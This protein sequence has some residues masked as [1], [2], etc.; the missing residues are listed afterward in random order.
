MKAA[1]VRAPTDSVPT[2]P[3]AGELSRLRGMLDGSVPLP[4]SAWDHVRGRQLEL[5]RDLARR[6]PIYLDSRFWFDLRRANDGLESAARSQPLLV[7]LREAVADGRAFCPISGSTFIELF[8][9]VDHQVRIRTAR[10]VQE[11]S[12]GVTLVGLEELA[13]TELEWFLVRK[14][15]L[16]VDPLVVPIWTRISYALG[17]IVPHAA[18]FSP[19]QNLALQVAAFDTLWNMPLTEMADELTDPP[20]FDL[21]DAARRL[22]EGIHAHAHQVADFDTVYRSEIVGTADFHGQ[23]LAGV[24]RRFAAQAGSPNGEP[25]VQDQRLTRNFVGNLLLLGKARQA[26]R[27]MHVRASLHA[28]IRLNKGRK[29]KPNDLPDIE[30]AVVGVGYCRAFFTEGSLATALGQKPLELDRLY[31]CLVTND[32]ER[33]L[34]FVAALRSQDPDRSSRAE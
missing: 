23:R 16:A 20:E 31:G 7:A 34:R 30:H 10:L 5:A 27:S 2:E 25:S 18:Q 8:R 6:T 32:V 21:V 24:I 13:E 3:S 33:A 28:I 19:R 22:T 1:R 29:F 12:L 17:T 9:H 15:D 4:R 11:L 26:L 14:A